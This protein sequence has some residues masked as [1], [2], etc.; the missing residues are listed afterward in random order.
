M[1]PPVTSKTLIIATGKYEANLAIKHFQLGK[2]QPVLVAADLISAQVFTANQFPFQHLSQ[3]IKFRPL[4]KLANLPYRLVT[5]WFKVPVV[6]AAFTVNSINYAPAFTE[7]LLHKILTSLIEF[8][9]LL[10][11]CHRTQARRLIIGSAFSP[12]TINLV[13]SQLKLK[14][15][16]FPQNQ[17]LILNRLQR[18]FKFWI[19]IIGLLIRHASITVRLLVNFFSSPTSL[20]SADI[21]IF[22]NGLHL[23]SYYSLVTALSKLKPTVALTDKQTLLDKFYLAQYKL[24]PPIIKFPR[25]SATS[26]IHAQ[27]LHQ[28]Q[29]LWKLPPR[30]S[31]ESILTHHLRSL[32]NSWFPAF[33]DK[34]HTAST[35]LIQLKPRLLIT[36]HDPGPT[37]MAFILAA[38]K[39]KIKTLVLLHGPSSENHYFFSDYQLIWGP[40]VKKFLVDQGIK[41][42]RLIPGGQPIFADYQR[43]FA[44]HEP[45]PH[46]FTIGI[47]TSG[48]GSNEVHQVD[49]FR[50]LIPALSQL[51]PQP[52]LVV[53]THPEQYI[54]GL[55][56]FARESGLSL[57]LNPPQTV[58]E[59]IASCHVIISQSST[60]TLIAGLSK[61]PVIFFPAFHP[62]INQ[63]SLWYNRMFFPVAH[64][65]QATQVIN[66]FV[67]YPST[68]YRSK[69]HHQ[70]RLLTQV[71]GPLDHRLGQRLAKTIQQLI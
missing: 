43:F 32:I 1:I 53:R 66:Q 64:A 9:N 29:S 58:E 11:A 31:H 15:N 62:L 23:A 56:D 67:H 2:K 10:S 50:K 52:C 71:C 28:T 24:N 5:V 34:F 49:Y 45:A 19:E 60:A 13:K 55:T 20:T 54:D 68:Y 59:F 6:K 40:L 12:L 69:L 47:L 38:Q 14:V 48:Y 65:K 17:L 18:S 26:R 25:Y 44:N 42:K 30:Q 27:L 37:P 33:L 8:F 51:T 61:K 39:I 3:L 22:S 35:L 57:S 63:G 41:L 16:Y 4:S 36:T 21:L 46:P 7:V 70:H